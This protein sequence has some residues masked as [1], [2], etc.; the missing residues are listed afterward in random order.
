MIYRNNDGDK[1]R[2]RKKRK[3]Q[4]KKSEMRWT[5]ENKKCRNTD[6]KDGRKNNGKP[7]N[8]EITKD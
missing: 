5:R 2:Q 8:I 1:T 7:L 3:I 6:K 4:N